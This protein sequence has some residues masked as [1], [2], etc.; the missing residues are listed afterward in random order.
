MME[1]E[2]EN[3]ELAIDDGE[4]DSNGSNNSDNEKRNGMFKPNQSTVRTSQSNMF[5]SS[6][7]APGG[8]SSMPGS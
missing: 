6:S 2:K 4:E 5:S 8:E 3:R 1:Q 7:R